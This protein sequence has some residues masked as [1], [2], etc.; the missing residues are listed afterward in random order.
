MMTDPIADMLTRIRNA[1]RIERPHVEIPASRVKLG[2]AEVLQRPMPCALVV[3]MVD[4]L[5]ARGGQI[6]FARLEAALGIPVLSVIGHRGVGIEQLEQLLGSAESWSRTPVPPPPAAPQV[7]VAELDKAIVLDWG[8][9]SAAVAATEMVANGSLEFEGYNV[10]QLPSAE[11]TL[12]Q[13]RKL[14]T[15]DLEN[16]VTTVLGIDLDDD[17][18]VILDVPLQIGTDFGVKR[19]LKVAQDLLRGR[20]L[21]NGQ[22]YYFAV[23]AY[24]HN[25]DENAATTTLES[26]PQILVAVPQLPVPGTRY[27]TVAAEM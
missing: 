27:G 22:R 3:T 9:N 17:S 4:E 8:W 25:K 15:F 10:Y 26:P 2:I 1:L 13:G 7:R 6:D 21:V 16:G 12:G 11:A 23:T 14:G 5:A 18:G 24:S 20:P 19:N